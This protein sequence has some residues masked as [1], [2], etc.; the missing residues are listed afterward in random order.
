MKDN[1]HVPQSTHHLCHQLSNWA[2]IVQLVFGEALIL[3]MEVVDWIHCIDKH[4]TSYN[5]RFKMYKYFGAKVLGAIDLG[6]YHYL[7]SCFTANKPEDISYNHLAWPNLHFN[8]IHNSLQVGLPPT[9]PNLSNHL[10]AQMMKSWKKTTLQGKKKKQH[11]MVRNTNQVSK[12]NCKKFYKKI[13][14]HD[15]LAITPKFNSA[16]LITCNNWH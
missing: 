13:F 14:T 6:T 16:G 9:W 10:P 2:G 12:W 1:F 5:A 3:A 7:E 11:G 4:E 8:I 15:I